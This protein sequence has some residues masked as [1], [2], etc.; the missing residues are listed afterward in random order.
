MSTLTDAL[1]EL[2]NQ[3]KG[4]SFTQ[5]EQAEDVEAFGILVANWSD[6][7]CVVPLKI[8]VEALTD[9]NWHSLAGALSD[10]IKVEEEGEPLDGPEA[11]RRFLQAALDSL[12]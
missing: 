9:A 7:D 1:Q 4:L 12:S 3:Q 10:A 5:P 6:W 11:A 8:T 2:I